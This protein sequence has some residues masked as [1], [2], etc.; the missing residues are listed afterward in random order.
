MF[1][2][3]PTSVVQERTVSCWPC[4]VYVHIAVLSYGLKFVTEERRRFGSATILCSQVLC[5]CGQMETWG[6]SWFVC[7]Q[8]LVTDN[9]V[10][11]INIFSVCIRFCLRVG[12]SKAD[13]NRRNVSDEPS[14]RVWM[15]VLWFRFFKLSTCLLVFFLLFSA[16]PVAQT[17]WHQMIGC[18]RKRSWHNFEVLWRYFE[19][20]WQYF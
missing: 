18:G 6:C 11:R 17:T 8:P 9:T 13:V 10:F 16:L 5:D 2:V 14:D 15:S 4:C 20:L 19:V 1:Y 7:L 3:R 12:M